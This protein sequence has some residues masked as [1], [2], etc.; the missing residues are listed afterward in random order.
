MLL[1]LC[2]YKDVWLADWLVGWYACVYVNVNRIAYKTELIKYCVVRNKNLIERKLKI[3]IRI[4]IFGAY[5]INVC[6]IV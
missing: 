3:L 4:R 5:E 6:E 1:I 2:I